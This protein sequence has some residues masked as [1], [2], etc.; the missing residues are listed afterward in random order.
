[1]RIINLKAENYKRLV[2]VE[3]TPDGNLVDIVGRN[4]QGKSSL[5]DSIY[6]TLAGASA[7]PPQPIHE[8]ATSAKIEL[9]LG[10]GQK[11]E[12]VVRRTFTLKESGDGYTT[13][14][15]VE[16]AEGMRHPSPQKL[17][18]TLL[19][20]LSFDPLE[21]TRM[22]PRD[23]L[24]ELRKLVPGVDFDAID[25][26]TKSDYDT[27]TDVNRELKKLRAQLA[28]PVPGDPRQ[29]RVDEAA[30]VS[31]LENAGNKQAEIERERARRQGLQ[32]SIIAKLDDAEFA[33]EKATETGALISKL[34]LDIAAL[35]TSQAEHIA[36]AGNLTSAAA[37]DRQAFEA[38]PPLED[39]PS[40]ADTVAQLNAARATN[41]L[42]DERDRAIAERTRIANEVQALDAKSK[43]L[44]ASIEKRDAELA[45][46]VA[47]AKLPIA[48]LAFGKD[49]VML[50]GF[51][52]E[53]ASDAERLRVSVAI[54]AAMNP[55]LRVVRIRDGSL[56]DP[57][58]VVAIAAFA[59][60]QNLQIWREVVDDG[61]KVG[62]VIEDGHVKAAP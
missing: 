44:S 50:N 9:T 54:A 14:V 61:H 18:D 11:I 1:M 31:I 40:T 13:A 2:A 62:I 19:G 39:Q 57:A 55:K 41:K 47:A 43:A 51:P 37:R 48:G 45:G 20:A 56:L 23:Q 38:L 27:R 22:K 7:I 6:V 5:L 8:G 58:G 10:D 35:E 3:V 32:R 46:A 24:D 12:L 17:L 52:L 60:E 26:A 16:N 34:Q 53:Q 36:R 15:V 4:G 29:V 49:A 59:A 28:A 42:V 30:L 25:A 21:F 33:T